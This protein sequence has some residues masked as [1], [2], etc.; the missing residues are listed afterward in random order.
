MELL[1]STGSAA[2]DADGFLRSASE[3]TVLHVGKSATEAPFTLQLEYK[4]DARGGSNT[5]KG[6]KGSAVEE[7][8]PWLDLHLVVEPRRAARSALRCSDTELSK[9]GEARTAGWEFG[10][11]SRFVSEQVV[12][13]S[14]DQTLYQH[15][16]KEDTAFATLRYKLAVRTG[17]NALSI[18]ATY[19][20]SGMTMSM[21]LYDEQTG[22]IVS[23]ERIS[24]LE[25]ESTTSAGA[26][27]TAHDTTTFIEIP[28]LEAGQYRLE[29]LVRR[30]LFLPSKKYTTCLG[31]DLVV[32]YVARTHKGASNKGMLYEILAIRPLRMEQLEVDTARVIEVDFDRELILDDLVNGPADRFYVCMLIND[33]DPKDTIHPTSVRK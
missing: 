8:C 4:H 12:I 32:E 14:D 16:D 5:N 6:Y 25:G 17:G 1:S 29:I 23:L 24:S 21:A 10:S 7:S 30:S 20:L 2:A 11:S 15:G 28:A 13:K 3:A 9:A 27:S 31:F 26:V 22:A 19:P 33:K 18:V